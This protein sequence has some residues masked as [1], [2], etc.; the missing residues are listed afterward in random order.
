MTFTIN[1]L[2]GCGE[3]VVALDEG[4]SAVTVTVAACGRRAAQG[5]ASFE[6]R[7]SVAYAAALPASTGMQH[8][9]GLVTLNG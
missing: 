9:N 2:C 4:F 5:I 8:R 3:T 6:V 7:K 1:C